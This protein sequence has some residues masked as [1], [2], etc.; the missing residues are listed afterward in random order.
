VTLASPAVALALE[1]P[2][3]RDPA[4][5]L[6][7]LADPGSLVLTGGADGAIRGRARLDGAPAVLFATDPRIQGGALGA[8]GCDVVVAAYADA[9]SAGLPVVGVWQ[10]GGARLREGAIGLDGVGRVFAA[11]TR[12]S[13]TVPQ[14]SLVLGPAA[15]GAAYGPA[16]TDVVVL[17]PDARL[18]VTGPDVVRSVTGETVDAEGLGGPAVHGRA[19]GVAHVV[20]GHLDEALDR[21]RRIVALL[22][23]PSAPFPAGRPRPDPGRHL[24]AARRRAYDVRPLVT[25][26]LDGPGE[27]LQAGWAPNIVTVLGRLHGRS[28][29]VLASNPIRLAGCL[30]AR[31]SDKAARFVRLCDGLG[32]PLVVLVDVPGYL[33]GSGQERDGVVRRGAKLVH[34]FASARVPRVTLITRKAYGGAYIA[35]NSRSLGAS[36]VLAWPGAEVDVMSPV[37]AVGVLHRRSLAG[38]APAARAER[39]AELAA[40]HGAATGGLARAVADGLVDA[41]VEPAASRDALAAALAGARPD[42]GRHTNIPL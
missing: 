33:P 36:A 30:D 3:P 14:V 20:T 6:A 2:D 18:F 1:D 26:L 31:A 11:M 23:R 15:G 7:A 10:C 42:R 34:A 38:L 12:A 21:T 27:E 39:E 22:S 24:P 40:E 9:L 13:G 37:A 8:E 25:D 41:V 19:S 35:M 5:R 29:G 4:G 28:V 16:L 32:V 17:A